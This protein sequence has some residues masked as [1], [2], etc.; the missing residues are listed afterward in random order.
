LV[1]I[2][3][4]DAA[5]GCQ[6]PASW[7]ATDR[8]VVTAR[9]EELVAR[10][11]TANPDGPAIIDDL[12]PDV[13]PRVTTHRQFDE[14]ARRFSATLTGLGVT[15]G[16]YVAVLAGH[17]GMTVA[18]I[19][20]VEH[21]G[22]AYVPL[23]PRW[24]AARMADVLGQ[25]GSRVLLTDSA[26]LARARSLA[27]LAATI[28]HIV[29]VDEQP[30]AEPLDAE[31]VADLW[32]SIAQEDDPLRAAG[33]NFSAREVSAGEVACY[34]DRVA[35]LVAGGA[36]TPVLEI[37]CGTGLIAS[38]LADR[39]CSVT[40]VDPSPV[41]LGKLRAAR[42]EVRTAV[43]CAGDLR[44]CLAADDRA[45]AGY[46]VAVL[47]SVTQFLGSTEALVDALAGAAAVLRPGGRLVLADLVPPDA[48]GPGHLAVA[49]RDLG[50]PRLAEVFGSVRFFERDA[51]FGRTLSR[52]YD[53]VLTVRP[54]A[55]GPDAEGPDAEG[56]EAAGALP[57]PLHTVP[58]SAVLGT[59]PAT[60]P[61]ATDVSAVAYAIFTSGTTGRPKGVTVSH[62]AVANLLDWVNREFGVTVDDRLLFVTSLA[63]DL[64]VY[65]MFGILAAGAGLVTLDDDI[66]VD[67][68][69]LAAALRRRRVTFWDSA[70]AALGLVLESLA[71]EETRLP[72]VRRVFLSGD[73]VPLPMVSAVR[74]RL[75]HAELVA[76]GGATEATVWSNSF[77][78][79]SL[80]PAWVSVPYGRPMQNSRYY[81]LDAGLRPAPVGEPGDLYIAGMCVAE[82]YLGQPELTA[83][84]FRA[85]P[86]WPGNR[87]YDTGDRARWLPDGNLEFLGR[88]DTQ[89]K[90]RGYRVELGD[91]RHAMLALPQMRDAAVVPFGPR[92]ARE[93]HA[94]W[95]GDV[96]TAGMRRHLLDSLPPYHVPSLLTPLDAMPVN[97]SGKVDQ[98]ALRSRAGQP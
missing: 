80:D 72:D 49:R 23:D 87:M 21:A 73:W 70:P 95:V 68:D 94:F 37:G 52:R 63:F 56:Q 66:L 27:D 39:G 5:A 76:L 18:A 86:F 44:S 22:A 60:S 98:A 83:E 71:E 10:G 4:D 36:G 84:R 32:D 16:E 74:D 61:A 14:A 46:E 57:R 8:P 92:E 88:R 93:L 15:P 20:G 29:L 58:V 48:A 77:R 82:G 7:F 53:A 26:R 6:P 35:G 47:A 81:V 67:P 89:V 25:T 12:G 43:G 42:P 41:A 1:S 78:V 3:P 38:A 50:D 2:A 9:I 19:V 51:S 97:D 64:S 28:E 90:V 85:D 40:G 13:P 91:I 96:D 79:G 11:A 59:P 30:P 17:R 62:A 75:P 69:E 34:V 24:P 45:A 54:D 31:D 65:D 55:G 33:F